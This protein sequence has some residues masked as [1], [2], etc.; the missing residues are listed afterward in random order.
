MIK[1]S[2]DNRRNLKS[3]KAKK[4]AENINKK[5][6]DMRNTTSEV[7]SKRKPKKRTVIDQS[8]KQKK[9]SMPSL[10]PSS[11]GSGMDKKLGKAI[12]VAIKSEKIN[13]FQSPPFR[14]GIP[15]HNNSKSEH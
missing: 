3:K 10:V 2:V 4:A 7:L 11:R 13:D 14:G 5:I 9:S 8:F 12:N 6:Y 15:T 1:N